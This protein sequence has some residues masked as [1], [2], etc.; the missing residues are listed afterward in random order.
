MSSLDRA[1]QAGD[2]RTEHGQRSA[3]GLGLK[4]GAYDTPK[5]NALMV[6]VLATLNFIWEFFKPAG[7][8]VLEDRLKR[9]SSAETAAHKIVTLYLRLGECLTSVDAFIEAFDRYLVMAQ[10]TGDP[11]D[12]TT[13]PL[14]IS[15]Q[16]CHLE[17][18]GEAVVNALI[19][20]TDAIA[21]VDPQLGIHKP[22]LAGLLQDFGVS[23]AQ[24]L[25]D[26]VPREFFPDLDSM[27][28]VLAQA[29]Q[30]RELLSQAVT[31]LQ[32]FIRKEFAFKELF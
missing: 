23:E 22:E 27:R 13:H 31:E 8:G 32:T 10:Q 5:E 24:L 17:D 18:R 2:P 15:E 25:D 21:A 14:A 16:S 12:P 11:S 28:D 4:Q 19:R 1:D 3:A 29:R 30:N 20:L 26:H 6:E 9:K 7:V